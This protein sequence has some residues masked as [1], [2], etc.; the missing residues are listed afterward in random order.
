[1]GFQ[2]MCRKLKYIKNWPRN[3]AKHAEYDVYVYFKWLPSPVFSLQFYGVSRNRWVRMA[4]FIQWTDENFLRELAPTSFLKSV[5]RDQIRT[6]RPVGGCGDVGVGGAASMSPGRECAEPVL[7]PS[8]VVWWWLWRRQ[9]EPS[10]MV[11]LLISRY[12]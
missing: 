3:R 7:L 6:S 12:K 5:V 8:I 1:M 10:G 11:S 4:L 2:I 9:H